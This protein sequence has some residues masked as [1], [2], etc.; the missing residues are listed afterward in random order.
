MLAQVALPALVRRFPRLRPAAD[1][2]RRRPA[3]LVRS[4]ERCPVV[5]G[6]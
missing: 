1:P 2:P 6:D 4:L 3:F 5:L